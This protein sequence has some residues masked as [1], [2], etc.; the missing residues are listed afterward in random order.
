MRQHLPTSEQVVEPSKGP[1]GWWYRLAA[2]P[3]P[4]ANAS[5]AARA[6]ARR[7][8]LASLLLL[9]IIVLGVAALP[10]G[11][12][13]L[14]TNPIILPAL[15]IG[16]LGCGVAA[17]FNRRG[18][19]IVV[20]ILLVLLLDAGYTAIVLGA[21]IDGPDL[22]IF[23]L[24]V[25]S[26]LVAVSLMAPVNVF[27]VAVFNSCVILAT[28][29]LAPHTP[30]LAQTLT[31]DAAYDVIARPVALQVIVAVV[32]YLFARGEERAIQRADRAEEIAALEARELDR[33]RQIEQG[34]EQIL[35]THVR[36]A[37]GDYTARAALGQNN[38]LWQVAVSLNN[39]LS[40]LQRSAQAEFELQ[41]VTQ[42]IGRLTSAI[43]NARAGRQPLWPAPSK[44]VLDPLIAELAPPRAANAGPAAPPIATGW[45]SNPS[46]PNGVSGQL[47][48]ATPRPTSGNLGR[49]E[50]STTSPYSAPYPSAYPPAAPDR[51]PDRIADN[52]LPYGPPA[53]PNTYP[54]AQPNVYPSPNGDAWWTQ[55]PDEEAN[56]GWPNGR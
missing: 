50:P 1:L 37:N 29:F 32:T 27:F 19:V 11:V 33:T 35:Q 15:V 16:I 38:I 43:Q 40:R 56:S 14:H 42:E 45:R 23:D 31:T 12:Y 48:A 4:S 7:G 20:A 54:N 8:Q 30:A 2:P 17:L 22:A 18:M 3:D 51:A 6:V 46:I 49:M 52:R 41:R 13:T 39:L 5:A 9:A 34:V 47:G 24:F 53:Q 25:F 28:L 21:P 55:L 10:I 26:E 44:T 36:A